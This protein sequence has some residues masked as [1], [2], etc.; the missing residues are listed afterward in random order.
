[1]T[2]KL[3]LL[4]PLACLTV[5]SSRATQ[6]H[7][8]TRSVE[9]VLSS[10]VASQVVDASVEAVF[11]QNG[12]CVYC[13][14]HQKCGPTEHTAD[15]LADTSQAGYANAHDDCL[16]NPPEGWCSGHPLC[17]GSADL[18]VDSLMRDLAT[19]AFAGEAKAL[20]EF[21]RRYPRNVRLNSTWRV[22]E[23]LRCPDAGVSYGFLPAESYPSIASALT[24]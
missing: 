4:L 18:K 9:R 5:L 7:I 21:V 16:G 14:W 8:A 12:N 6:H 23:I 10:P 2:A 19:R 13:V 15:Y 11:A 22:I 17:G 3:T 20:A 24:G 1:M